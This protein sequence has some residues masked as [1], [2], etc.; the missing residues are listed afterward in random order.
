MTCTIKPC[1]SRRSSLRII[2]GYGRTAVG[3]SIC[4]PRSRTSTRRRSDDT[5]MRW[6]TRTAASCFLR[7]RTDHRYSPPIRVLPTSRTSKRAGKAAISGVSLLKE[8]DG[9]KVWVQVGEDLA[10]RDVIVDDIV[11]DFFK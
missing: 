11:A 8:V 4:L 5:P 7:P 10:H 1:A 9:R 6:S 3:P 2:S